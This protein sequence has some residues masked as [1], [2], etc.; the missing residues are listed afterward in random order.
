MAKTRPSIDDPGVL[1]ELCARITEGDGIWKVCKAADMPT[2]R[3]VYRRMATSDE[4]ASQIS[5]AR[6]AQQD[7]RS[8]EI[9]KMAEAATAEN[10]QA[11]RLRIWAKQ[12]QAAKL[13]P[14]KYGVVTTHRHGGEDG[15]AIPVRME[16]LSDSQLRDF[17]ARTRRAVDDAERGAGGG[18]SDPGAEGE[19]SGL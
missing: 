3:A 15:G 1:E 8:D 18:G 16:A 14:K 5:R 19:A 9:D 17:V 11:V 6:E 7:A 13:A 10:W 2:A 12:W 4:V